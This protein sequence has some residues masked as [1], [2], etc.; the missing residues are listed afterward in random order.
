MKPM[1]GRG[2]SLQL[3]LL[4]AVVASVSLIFLDSKLDLFSP[5]RVF[6]NSLVSPLQYMA[7]APSQLLDTVADKVISR[8][9][10]QAKN[11]E[12]EHQVFLVR[13]DL[14]QMEHLKEENK[15]LRQLLGSP[16]R[17][18]A[19]KMVAEIM[20]VD[21]DPF[22]HQVVIDKGSLNGVFEGQPVVNDQGV[23]GQVLRVG[24]TTSR[25]LLITDNSHGIPV[26]FQRNDIRALANGT[27]NLERLD[28]P[29]VPHSTDIQEGDVLVTSG[30]GGRFPEGYPIAVIERFEYDEGMP[31][32]R[33]DAKPVVPLDRIRY[34]LL[35]W[36][37]EAGGPSTPVP[38]N[39]EEREVSELPAA[40]VTPA[41]SQSEEPSNG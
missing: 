30:L 39:P 2:P 12:L 20:E 15:R 37:G 18:D 19:R 35:L 29:F 7:N 40:E 5:Y 3:R 9:Q 31:Y 36:P 4:L 22:T 24:S 23:V 38:V 1:F 41:P 17:Q 8:E 11:K 21:S 33:V 26:R 16:V 27:G 10:L 32:A 28:I 25:V 13:S 14:L 34:L 6:L